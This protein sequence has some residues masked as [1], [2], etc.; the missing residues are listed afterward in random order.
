MRRMQMRD[1]SMS[2]NDFLAVLFIKQERRGER[3]EEDGE[4][5]EIIQ[6]F[7][8]TLL[9]DIV[10]GTNKILLQGMSNFTVTHRL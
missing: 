9:S 2:V 7:M 4:I 1:L 3:R 5:L 8:G 10:G 6:G